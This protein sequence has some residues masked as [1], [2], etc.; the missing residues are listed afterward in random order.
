MRKVIVA[1]LLLPVLLAACGSDDKTS[2]ADSNDSTTAP[3]SGAPVELAGKT[4]AHGTKDA[5]GAHD[6]E[7]EADDFYFGP[8]FVKVTAGQKL[9]LE[10]KNEGQAP[11]TFTS[12]A[13]GVDKELKPGDS[14]KVE[15]TV[16]TTD[17]SLFYC[18]FHQSGGMQGAVFT[19][20]GGTI[21]APTGGADTTASSSNG[22]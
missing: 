11:H 18:R 22:Y 21:G 19:K 16:P 8:T 10:V 13:L 4:T 7:I 1:M 9:T 3:A 5:T 12:D 2:T 20:E 15:I 14:A 17:G 6:L